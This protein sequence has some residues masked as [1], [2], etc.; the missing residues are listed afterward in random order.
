MLFALGQ[1]VR[2][3]TCLCHQCVKLPRA[4]LVFSSALGEHGQDVIDWFGVVMGLGVLGRMDAAIAEMTDGPESAALPSSVHTLETNRQILDEP[5]GA[6][7][8]GGEDAQTGY[9]WDYDFR[10]RLFEKF[11][12]LV[13]M[14]E[15]NF[16]EHDAE[17]GT[18]MLEKFRTCR[19]MIWPTEATETH[20]IYYQSNSCRLRWC[21]ACAE[22][23]VNTIAHG[24]REIFK[25]R[26]EVR[27]LTLTQKHNEGSLE[28]Q[29]ERMKKNIVRLRRC[30]RWREYVKGS[31][32]FL[33]YKWSRK[34]QGW[35]VHCHILLNGS[36]I[37][38]GWLS[39][40]W[41]A[42]T[43]DSYVVDVRRV[44]NLDSAI[45]DATRYAGR[46]ANLLEIPFERRFEIVHA[47]Q[48]VRLFVRTGNCR[49]VP[50]NTPKYKQ[51]DSSDRRLGRRST[52]LYFA[53]AGD[54]DARAI[55]DAA[56]NHVP[57]ENARSFMDIANFIDDKFE[58][59]SPV[60]P[61]ERGRDPPA[62]GLFDYEGDV[63]AE[64]APW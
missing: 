29:T 35:H 9:S 38:Q 57:L 62:Q 25:R 33:H 24:C 39:K 63:V 10:T 23:R 55:L 12:D 36:Y 43:G 11:P 1:S 8:P 50:I 7:A 30:S 53:R 21:P 54:E 3:H 31:I 41:L 46:P 32:G 37:P 49:G 44:R 22:A 51:G 26:K 20:E 6:F 17:Y 2:S 16:G 40:K 27:L 42:V 61:M 15:Q 19:T 45:S 48:G 64:N 58:G 60:E 13:P 34:S 47:T 56:D 14:V 52:I 28:E 4:E 59:L 5:G 18:C